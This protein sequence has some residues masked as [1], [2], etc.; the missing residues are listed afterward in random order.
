MSNFSDV[1]THNWLKYDLTDNI[2]WL[3][4]EWFCNIFQPILSASV[5]EQFIKNDKKVSTEFTTVENY[6][7]VQ[8]SQVSKKNI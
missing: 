6:M 1:S 2:I 5:L 4:N 8:V 7:E 3:N